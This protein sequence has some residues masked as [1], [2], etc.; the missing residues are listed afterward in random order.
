MAEKPWGGMN[1]NSSHQLWSRWTFRVYEAGK[2]PPLGEVKLNAARWLEQGF[3]SVGRAKV[4]ELVRGYRITAEVEGPP[5]HDPQY[6]QSVRRQ[7][8]NFVEKGWGPLATSS[9]K[10]V[11]LAGDRQDGKPLDQLVVIPKERLV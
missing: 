8:R 4:E 9:L 2:H 5:A 1:P 3:G 11:V 10:A 6:V 7:F